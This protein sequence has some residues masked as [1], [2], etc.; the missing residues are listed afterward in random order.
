MRPV[1]KLPTPAVTSTLD[2]GSGRFV[3]TLMEP[4]GKPGP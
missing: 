4:P 2:T 3:I 1:P